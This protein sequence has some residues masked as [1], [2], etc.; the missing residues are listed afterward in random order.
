MSLMK[1]E[2]GNISS[3]RALLWITELFTLVI[4]TCDSFIKSV[5]TPVA[6]YSLLGGAIIAFAAWAGG[7]RAMMYL[8]PKVG[9]V[10]A[11]I[12]QSRVAEKLPD[13]FNDDERG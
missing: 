4:I 8:G 10:M 9:E 1:D 3:A 5:D 11:G 6:A 2:M 13:V 12:A 7:P